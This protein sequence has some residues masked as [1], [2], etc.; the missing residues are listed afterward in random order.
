MTIPAFRTDDMARWGVGLGY[1]LPAARIDLN[2]W[3][4]HV[5]ILTME[6]NPTPGRGIEG[7]SV[8]GNQMTVEMDDATTE[9]PFT[10][11]TSTI[12]YRGVWAASTNYTAMDLVK[13]SGQGMFLVLTSHVSE[14]FFDA[15][16]SASNGDY[17]VN[18]YPDV[19]MPAVVT[20]GT[21]TLTASQSHVNKYN[22]CTHATGCIVTVGANTFNV[23]DEM[24]FR[25]CN[26]GT[27]RFTAGAGVTFSDFPGF[28]FESG[29]IGSI[30]TVKCIAAD[31]FDIFGRLAESSS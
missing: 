16:A 2:F 22:R 21:T 5:R 12:R 1:N 15:N 26:A 24:H 27:V 11:P 14:S 3:E 18:L 25:Q 13:V 9:G 10:L 4:M 23:A 31:T 29:G 20:V 17:Y 6:E 19:S 30:V 28:D 7:F 8:S